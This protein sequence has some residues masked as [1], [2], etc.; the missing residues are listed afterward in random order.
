MASRPLKIK[1]GVVERLIKEEDSYKK[2]YDNQLKRI[3][4]VKQ[5]TPDDDWNIRKQKEV[6]DETIKMIPDVKQRLSKAIEELADLVS[7]HETDLAGTEEL[8]KAQ[9]VLTLA[10]S[11][12]AESDAA[13]T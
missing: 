3:E 1:T 13:A 11:R 12:R 8:S 6:L 4:K 9:Q 2:E 7:A 5:E 10:A